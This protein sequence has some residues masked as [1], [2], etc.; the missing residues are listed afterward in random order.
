MDWRNFPPLTQL[1]AFAAFADAPTLEQAGARIGVTHAAIS[2][3]IRALETHLGLRL[4]DRGGRKLVLTPEGRVLADAL[5]AGFGQIA[6]AIASLTGADQNAPLRVTTTPTFAAGWLMPRLSDFRAH[7]PEIDLAIDPVSENRDIGREA[8]IG[9]RYGSGNWPGLEAH[10]ILRSSIVVVAAP[11]LVPDLGPTGDPADLSQ[12]AGLT[13]LQELGT[14]EVTAFFQN[15]QGL[16]RRQGGAILSMP[17]NLMLDAAR[18]GQGVAVIARAFVER[19]IAAGRLR[20]LM[21]DKEREGYFL[22]HR[23]GLLKPAQ[24]AFVAWALRQAEAG[25]R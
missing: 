10:L 15:T 7:H 6:T 3:Q 14:S 13:W 23:P 5:D 8:D 9:L 2:Q 16:T 18:D 1:R 12:L 4:V 11:S 25:T 19:D 21:E 20:L 24:K 17:G 22:I